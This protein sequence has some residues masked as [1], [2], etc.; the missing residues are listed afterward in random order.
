MTGIG[1][2]DLPTT[3]S[4]NHSDT[5]IQIYL[6]QGRNRGRGRWGRAPPPEFHTFAED[7][8]LIEAHHILH[9]G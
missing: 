4:I 3:W 8:S 2:Q 5:Q 9:L 6:S 7:M 1:L